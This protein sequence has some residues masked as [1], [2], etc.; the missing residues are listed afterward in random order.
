MV[1]NLVFAALL[2]LSGMHAPDP[3]AA[4]REINEY[5]TAQTQ[6]ARA[7][8]TQPDVAAINAEVKKR[9][10][11]AIQGVQ[12][13]E[14][15]PAKAYSWMQLFMMAQKYEDIHALCATFMKSEP[16]P[17][18]AFN[19]E[20]TCVQAFYNLQQWQHGADTLLGMEPN[21]L[22]DASF[23]MSYAG[24]GFAPNLA[25]TDP[26]AAVKLLDA[27]LAKVPQPTTDA[28]K[29]QVSGLVALYF[30]SKANIFLNAGKQDEGLA[31][32]D[33]ALE[34]SRIADANKRSIRNTRIRL[35]LPGNPAPAIESSRG[36]GEYKGL[37][38]LKGK[39]V[40]IDFFAH[41]CP[42]CKAA[43]PDMR[44]MY[45]D[46]KDQGFEIIGVTR[47]YG[48]YE[49]EQGL[50]QDDEFARMK[51]FNEQFNINWPIIYD[52]NNSFASYGVSGIPTVILIDKKGNVNKVHVG[53]SKE[54]FAAFRKE[55]ERLLSETE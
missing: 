17:T 16:T 55:V 35:G 13:S 15:E 24:Q 30:E 34:D 45:D 50:S 12:P 26:E 40:M 4:I 53:Y 22:A 47:Y 27:V 19:A 48:Y 51:G 42:P 31:I 36:Y 21:T 25:K 44:Q 23:M 54:S 41:W 33:A 1:T 14:V 38:S 7:A 20:R 9:A 43:F 49:R 8:G 46:L 11:A 10:E 52:A 6:A 18:A 32:L 28:E 39:V 37:D 5:R 2:G 29:T 3:D